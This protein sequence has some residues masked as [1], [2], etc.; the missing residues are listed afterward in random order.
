MVAKSQRVADVIEH[1]GTLASHWPQASPNHLQMQ[2][3]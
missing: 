3:H 1:Y 2:C